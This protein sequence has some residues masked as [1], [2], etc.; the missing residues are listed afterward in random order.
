MKVKK[1]KTDGEWIRQMVWEEEFSF[2]ASGLNKQHLVI[3]NGKIISKQVSESG[4]KHPWVRTV[5]ATRK[6]LNLKGFGDL[7]K[8]TPLYKKAKALEKEI[9]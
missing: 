3:K 7:R 2:T 5:A 1:V 6:Q 9:R 4:K 8:G